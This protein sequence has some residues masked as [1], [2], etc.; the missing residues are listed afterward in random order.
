[1][2]FAFVNTSGEDGAPGFAQQH[3]ISHALHFHNDFLPVELLINGIPH[4]MLV[5]A[6]GTVVRN[7]D[8]DGTTLAAEVERLFVAR[9]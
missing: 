1:M 7:W 2:I 8:F 5:A 3:G 4:K 6:D 9:A